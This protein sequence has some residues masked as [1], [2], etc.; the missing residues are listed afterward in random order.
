MRPCDSS[1]D[2]TA[3]SA[4]EALM[5]ALRRAH[6][7]RSTTA[8]N[9]LVDEG[10]DHERDIAPADW[11]QM[12]MSWD[13]TADGLE[14]MG[15]EAA[16]EAMRDAEDEETDEDEPTMDAAEA[17]RIIREVAERTNRAIAR[18]EEGAVEVEARAIDQAT[19]QGSYW[20]R[21]MMG[22]REAAAE[23][24]DQAVV[25]AIDA[26]G[27]ERAARV[28]EDQR[29]ETTA[30]EGIERAAHEMVRLVL[31]EEGI[32]QDAEGMVRLVLE[33]SDAPMGWREA[34]YKSAMDTARALV[35][36]CGD[37]RV[38]ARVIELVAEKLHE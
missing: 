19:E 38:I 6:A 21:L 16:A 32:E 34:G 15:W 28:Y 30:E 11:D 12:A 2:R 23:H 7:V 3:A 31:A 1:Y 8:G 36:A 37:D 4:T 22:T 27:V 9:V 17:E 18:Q 14:S 24:G 13:G 10:T 33:D 25:D 35:G 20:E 29:E 5:E 26:L